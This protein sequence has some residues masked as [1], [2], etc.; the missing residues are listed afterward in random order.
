MH[1]TE[2]RKEGTK[3]DIE[4]LKKNREKH[5]WA[6]PLRNKKKH[7]GQSWSKRKKT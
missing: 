2:G 1:Q 4:E 3:G 7:A 5:R 6:K